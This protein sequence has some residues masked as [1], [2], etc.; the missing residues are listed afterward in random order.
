MDAQGDQDDGDP[1]SAPAMG[2]RGHRRTHLG[3]TR[4]FADVECFVLWS[5][6]DVTFRAGT[7]MESA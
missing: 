5:K 2:S 6:S 3:V 4:A 7:V 1:L